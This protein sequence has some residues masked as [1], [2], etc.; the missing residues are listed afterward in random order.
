MT[1]QKI[2][3]F[4]G[5]PSVCFSSACCFPTD[6]LRQ[7]SGHLRVMTELH[8]IARTPRCHRAKL[9]SVAEHLGE[10]H[11]G[12]HVLRRAAAFHAEDMTAPGREVAHDVAEVL[13][14]HDDVD[15]HDRLE[16]VG[17]RL[18]HSVLRSEEHTSELQSLMYLVCRLLL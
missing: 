1:P 12:L 10:G 6:C 13:L 3:D 16:Q 7:V 2:C 9:G 5:T 8:R 4:L 15:L 17:L 18:V 14:G 11:V